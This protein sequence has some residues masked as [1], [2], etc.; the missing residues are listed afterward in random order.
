MVRL[1]SNSNIRE[2][3]TTTTLS[4]VMDGA[5]ASIYMV[6]LLLASFSPLGICFDY[7]RKPV[8]CA[9]LVAVETKATP[10]REHK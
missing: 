10:V 4:A 9:R 5:M 1:D 8:S 2:I 7:G 6:F 3:L